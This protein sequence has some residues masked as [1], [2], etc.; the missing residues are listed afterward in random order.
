MVIDANAHVT[1]SYRCG[2]AW[3]HPWTP[4]HHAVNVRDSSIVNNE[5]RWETIAKHLTW[6]LLS[7]LPQ[8][9]WA[10]CVCHLSVNLP[11]SVRKLCA[12]NMY[13]ITWLWREVWPIKDSQIME[14]FHEVLHHWPQKQNATCLLS[15]VSRMS[16]RTQARILGCGEV[17]VLQTWLQ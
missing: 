11:R 6:I 8:Q 13:R 2:F 7:Q 5:V 14:W 9:S 16:A 10:G 12:S 1:I 3:L 15:E 4:K 17:G